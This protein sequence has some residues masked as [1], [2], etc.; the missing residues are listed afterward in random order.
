[1]EVKDREGKTTV[2]PL[3]SKLPGMKVEPKKK[4]TKKK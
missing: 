2:T 4:P 3:D 1:M